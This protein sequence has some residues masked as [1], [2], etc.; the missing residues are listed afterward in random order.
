[1]DDCA[2]AHRDLIEADSSGAE[3]RLGDAL[4]REFEASMQAIAASSFALDSFYAAVK[5]RIEIPAELTETWRRNRRARWKQMAEVFRRAFALNEAAATA[6]RA[7]FK[8]LAKYRQWAVHPP[9]DQRTPVL[10]EDIARGVEWRFVAFR[11]SNA[12]VIVRFALGN[13]HILAEKARPEPAA[14][15]KYCEALTSALEP[16]RASWAELANV[17]S[18]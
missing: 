18:K 6:L 14:L 15:K 5:E 1:L 3:D 4:G 17:R 8:E 9:A 10:R 7:S 13:I 11:H 12:R 2:A 16:L